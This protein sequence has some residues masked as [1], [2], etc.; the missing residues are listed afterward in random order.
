MS[1]RPTFRDAL[2]D[3]VIALLRPVP[4]IALLILSGV[5]LLLA[6]AVTGFD[7][8]EVLFSMRRAE[9]ARGLI[10]YLFALVTIGTAVCLVVSALIGGEN[11]EK[12]FEQGKDILAL[13]LGV[14]GTIVGFYFGSELAQSSASE[15]GQLA[16]TT[17][18][19][20]PA[21][22]TTGQTVTVTVAVRGGTP[23]Y[24]FGLGTGETKPVP[25]EA[26]RSD[27]WATGFL[28]VPA[29]TEQSV[30]LT[31]IVIDADGETALASTRVPLQPPGPA[32]P[33]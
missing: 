19:V 9:F 1:D 30:V 22:A 14:F 13:L 10:T 28:Q 8:G 17:P 26:V 31:V 16:V 4:L 20:S 7:K 12:R 33:K 3:A 27:G 23:P 21:M 6:A 25:V 29:S 11:I 5:L 15:R 32:P 2:G 24:Q 18:L